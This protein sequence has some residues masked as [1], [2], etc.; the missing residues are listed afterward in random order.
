MDALSYTELDMIRD[1][2]RFQV[3]AVLVAKA[4]A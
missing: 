1:V 3:K 2:D 4:S